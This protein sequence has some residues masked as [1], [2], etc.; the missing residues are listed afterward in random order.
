MSIYLYKCIIICTYNVYD[1]KRKKT[2]VYVKRRHTNDGIL[3]RIRPIQAFV[4]L[5]SL[6]S[7][8]YFRLQAGHT[9]A[10]THPE[11]LKEKSEKKKKYSKEVRRRKLNQFC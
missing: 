5:F 9:H 8:I 7:M 11:K 3:I 6:Y 4:F 10:H 2:G 1:G